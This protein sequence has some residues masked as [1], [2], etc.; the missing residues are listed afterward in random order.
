MT[1]EA[2]NL[3]LAELGSAAITVSLHTGAGTEI[4]GAG[5]SRQSIAWAAPVNGSM[6]STGEV[7]FSVPAGS[8][9]SLIKVWDSVGGTEY[10]IFSPT[11]ETFG[12]DG[13]YIVTSLTVN[14]N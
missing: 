9:V 5:Y 10:L 12:S 4:T 14:I 3:M 13:E 7:T 11:D 2:K 6:Q 1:N 8:T